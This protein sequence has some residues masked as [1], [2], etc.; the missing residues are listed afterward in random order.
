MRFDLGN[1]AQVAL[2]V[3]RTAG[4]AC[5]L[6]VRPEHLVVG[7]P[8]MQLLVEMVESLGADVLIHAETGGQSLVIRAPADMKLQAGERITAGFDPACLHWFDATT[9]QRM[10]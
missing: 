7:R 5:I 9:T 1:G 3:A 6:G 10:E 4:Q 8:G 2:P